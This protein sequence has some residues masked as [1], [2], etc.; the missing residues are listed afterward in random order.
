MRDDRLYLRHIAEC[1]GRVEQYVA[2]GQNSFMQS[3]LIQDAV[4]RNLQV[5]GESTGRISVEA[6]ARRP[7][8]DWH[9]I[10]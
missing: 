3:T 4:L 7:E 5:L 1:I 9:G 2:G 6:R 8:I 10:T